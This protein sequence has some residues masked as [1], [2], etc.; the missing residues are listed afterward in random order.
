VGSGVIFGRELLCSLWLE[1]ALVE[2][3]FCSF[4]VS[5]RV[6]NCSVGKQPF[7][8]VSPF[9]LFNLL[10]FS[11]GVQFKCLVLV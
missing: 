6:A 3:D 1:L 4:L 11:S 9:N 5:F 10:L 2:K 8:V 7:C